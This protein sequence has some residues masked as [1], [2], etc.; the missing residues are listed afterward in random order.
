MQNF[1]YKS[2]FLME[3]GDDDDDDNPVTKE[4]QMA[5]MPEMQFE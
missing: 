5:S 4:N 1:N 3:D 2:P